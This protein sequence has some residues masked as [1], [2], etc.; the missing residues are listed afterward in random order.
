MQNVKAALLSLK[1]VLAEGKCL[2]HLDVKAKKKDCQSLKTNIN[3]QTDVKKK[4]SGK[5]ALVV[6][7][8]VR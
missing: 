3:A 6:P 5:V 8:V 1:T 2:E 7:C 4:M